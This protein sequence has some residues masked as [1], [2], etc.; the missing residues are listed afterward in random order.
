MKPFF[1]EDKIQ[2]KIVDLLNTT[3]PE[4]VKEIA[5]IQEKQETGEGIA[6]ITATFTTTSG[7]QLPIVMQ[8]KNTQ[9][10][11]VLRDAMRQTKK[12]AQAMGAVPMVAGVFWGKRVRRVAK[13]ENVGLLDLAGNFYLQKDPVLIEKTVGKNP[14][15]TTTPLKS[16]FSP[17][18]TRIIRA[19]LIEP[20]RVWNLQKL[21]Q[22]TN[23]SIGQTYKVA[24]RLEA[25][26]FGK[27]NKKKQF[28]LTS[29]GELVDEWIKV[30]KKNQNERFVFYSF[31]KNLDK[32]TDKVGVINKKNKLGYALGYFSGA[33]R[34]APFIRGFNKL[35]FFVRSSKEL[36]QYKKELKLSLVE[37]GGNVEIFLPYDKGVF[38]KLQ[39][40]DGIKIV[41][42][43]QLYI[44]LVNHP[45][46]GREQ[47]QHLRNTVI[48]F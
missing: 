10:L 40:I 46:R 29:P 6:D 37:S 12:L 20:N 21:S 8:V 19:I 30:Y 39:K 45:A 47:A 17:V 5:A 13:E 44:D 26:E 22:E 33:L 38:Y 41:S 23:V 25:E 28:V 36:E 27:R 43:I 18:S 42:N 7:M 35:Q 16:L 9:R 4:G 14:F 11:I 15:S 32:L 3:F 24:D 1:S 48:K 34:I 2:N 31:E